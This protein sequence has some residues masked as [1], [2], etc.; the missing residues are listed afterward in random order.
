MEISGV[1]RKQRLQKRFHGKGV[2]AI[3]PE[4]ILASSTLHGLGLFAA[5]D[6][7]E[8]CYV[9]EYAGEYVTKEVALRMMEDGTD[10]HLVSIARAV[11]VN[12]RSC[13][14]SVHRGLVLLPP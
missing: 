12:R 4:L 7:E 1:G 6:M 8:G 5:H 11:F 10:T 13:A 14:W 3:L 9:T 2:T